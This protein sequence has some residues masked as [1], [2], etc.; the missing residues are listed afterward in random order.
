MKPRHG[1]AIMAAMRDGQVRRMS[2]LHRWLYKTTRG[3][4]GKRLVDND[5][6]L[7]TTTGRRTG[8]PHTVP[9]LYLREGETVVLIASY[10]GRDRHPAWYLNLA[11]TPEVEVQ[12]RQQQFKARA[13]TADPEERAA[14]WPRV[15]AAYG[16]YAVYQTR[17]DRVIPVV[18]LEPL[19]EGAT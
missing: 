12:L 6:L 5:I 18:L 11:A 2:R 7:L 16:D 8:R 14:W 4:V 17:T 1:P 9:L 15:V 3:A 13:R 19:R 10:G